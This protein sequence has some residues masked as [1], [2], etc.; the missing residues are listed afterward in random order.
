MKLLQRYVLIE[1]LRVFSLLVCGLT[2]LLVVV[3]VLG[4]AAANGLGPKQILDIL[5]Y[6]VPSLLPFTIPA[7]L[8]L[9]TC[10]VYGR[11]S[12][13]Q[14]ITATKAAGISVISLL[15]PSF[16]LAA[17][18]SLGTFILTDQFI[19]WA[20]TNIQQII[21]MAMEDIFLDVLRAKQ[22]INQVDHGISIAVIRVDGKRLIHPT[23]QYESKDGSRVT[24]QA[25]EATLKFD[26][27]KKQ[28]L[29][30]LYRGH[31]ATAG[32]VAVWFDRTSRPFPLPMSEE[33]ERPRNLP[34]EKIRHE[35]LKINQ[36]R[37]ERQH[38]QMALTAFALTQGQFERL[39][40]PVLRV[41]EPRMNI[42]MARYRKL[43]TEVHSRLALACS[44]FFFVLVGSP[45]SILQGKRQFLTNF[46]LCF[47]PI[48]LFYYPIVLL[49]MNL[50]K[51]DDLNAAWGMWIGN[52]VLLLAGLYILRK[53]LRY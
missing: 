2:I 50:A 41:Y 12:G 45:F 48:L 39:N 40:D 49:T 18:L 13:D 37:H 16:I 20:R 21:T 47:V 5:P 8:L 1:L 6:V 11:M 22:Q 31:I 52:G 24:I 34:I 27:E 17:F 25:Q 33:E 32:Q 51:N 15:W 26:L 36:E 35:M 42:L 4:E 44:C 10:V 3:G 23:F 46:F 14:E 9:T 53:V 38:K 19:P 28:V 43:D 29:L 30:Q 7:T